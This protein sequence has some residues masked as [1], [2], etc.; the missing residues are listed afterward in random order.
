MH[1]KTNAAIKFN[2]TYTVSYLLFNKRKIQNK[3]KIIRKPIKNKNK[4]HVCI[5]MYSIKINLF[6][7]YFDGDI[8][9]DTN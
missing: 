7:L 1:E 9:L 2:L 3:T 8:C 5:S 4:T 6:P